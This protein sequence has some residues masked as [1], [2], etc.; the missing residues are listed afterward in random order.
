M[1]PAVQPIPDS[2]HDPFFPAQAEKVGNNVFPVFI[3][4]GKGAQ[5]GGVFE[6][7]G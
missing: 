3:E 5:I 7:N 2:Q 4:D 6:K 1:A